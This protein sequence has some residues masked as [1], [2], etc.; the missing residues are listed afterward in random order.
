VIAIGLYLLDEAKAG[1]HLFQT[2]IQIGIRGYGGSTGQNNIDEALESYINPLLEH[3]AKELESSGERVMIEDVVRLRFDILGND[4]QQAFPTTSALLQKTANYCA[5]PE[6]QGAWFHVATSCRELLQAFVGELVAQGIVVASPELKQGDAKGILK[7]LIKQKV[8]SGE[9]I[10]D[11]VQAV[12]V[13]V[14]VNVHRQ[15]ATKQDALR[16]Y[17]WTGLLMSE[18]WL[19]V[20]PQLKGR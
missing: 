13:Y 9:T 5:Q 12:W 18:V 6:E 3:I 11:L 4:F 20:Q 17:M 2:A 15:S 1:H 19:L 7:Q 8:S 10:V 14:S 16:A